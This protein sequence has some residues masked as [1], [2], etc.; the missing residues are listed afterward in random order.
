MVSR[1]EIKEEMRKTQGM[2]W[3]D[4]ATERLIEGYYEAHPEHSFKRGE[5]K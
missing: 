2:E 3:D 1:E 5:N 4:E